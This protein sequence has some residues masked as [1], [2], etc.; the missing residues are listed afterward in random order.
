M[1]NKMNLKKVLITNMIVLI[2][3]CISIL[4]VNYV[5]Y[6]NYTRNFNSKVEQIISKIVEKYPNVEKNELIEILN[7]ENIEANEENILKNYGIDIKKDSAILKN[8]IEF[9][10]FE[11]LLLFLVIFLAISTTLIIANYSKDNKKKINEITKYIEQINR[12]N[13]SL[14]IEENSE[15]ELSILKNEIYKTTVMLNEIAENET[16]DK[17]NLKESLSDISHQLKTP[18]TSIIIMLDN[19]LDNKEMSQE[20]REEFIKDI[21]REITNIQFLIETLLKLS[22]LDANSVE[23]INKEVEVEEIIQRAVKNV[24]MICDLKNIKINITGNSK[25]KLLC[26]ERW[27][28]EAITNILKNAAEHSKNNSQI[29]INYTQNKAYTKI[30]IK[31]NGIG[32]NEE[33]LKHI[34]ERFYKGKNA[35]KDSV[36][37]GLALAKAIIEKNNGYI[38]VT[39]KEN[40]GTTFI[41]KSCN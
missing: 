9:A 14:D 29:D 30:K 34:F 21:K 22:K 10:K 4:I 13:Y 25:E 41:I 26:D 19:I 28:I 27:Q 5:E 12:R 40:E 24:A 8:D 7:S 35:S 3:F 38:T 17:Q 39:S 33:D 6:Q 18:L 23:F 20:V 1:K 16:K 2:I 11:N 37:I 31:D 36:G 32:I 15:D